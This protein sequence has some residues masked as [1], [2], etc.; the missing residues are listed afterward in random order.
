[1]AQTGGRSVTFGSSLTILS[2]NR[3]FASLKWTQP[4]HR[5]GAAN[6][7]TSVGVTGR[8]SASNSCVTGWG[9]ANSEVR[10]SSAVPP[11][12]PIATRI[13]SA[14]IAELSRSQIPIALHAAQA[15]SA[16]STE[17]CL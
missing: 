9:L 14:V 1:M 6:R 17:Q 12:T 15:D 16:Q 4:S 7:K 10:G 13:P 8:A 11:T 3:Q 2:A 5:H